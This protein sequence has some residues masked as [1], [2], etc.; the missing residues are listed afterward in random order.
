MKLRIVHETRYRYGVPVALCHNEA[1][2]LVRD[3]PGQRCHHSVLQIDPHPT[4]RVERTDSF[5]NRVVYFALE[6][7]HD[8]LIVTANS[9][10]E[11]VAQHGALDVAASP[12]WETVR[13]WLWDVARKGD[14]ATDIPWSAAARQ[15]A[16]EFALDSTNITTSA[17]LAD[18]AAPSFAP[19]R[20]LLAVIRDLIG[21]IHH[22]FD[23][24]PESTDVA[25]PL[26]DVLAL[27]SGVCQDFA[28]LAIGCLRSMGLAGRYVS[29]Y[30]ETVPPPGQVRLQ[31]A[32]RSHAWF[33][34][35][36]PGHGWVDADPT[37]NQ[38][39]PER[40]LTIAWGRD[41]ADVAPLKGVIF[42]GGTHTLDVAVDV[43]RVDEDS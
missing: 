24:N 38:M 1:R 5:G 23:F 11:I 21:R 28:H 3:V 8:H 37:N 30:L 19:Q 6:A 40:H 9:E 4:Q 18:Y 26:A 2:L 34:V 42:G 25:T 43:V 33:A 29:G 36:V 20:P 27:R 12:A 16:V 41:Y 32:D 15:E 22:D 39:P 17:A 14:S 7:P 35:Y 31:G 10:V 13:E